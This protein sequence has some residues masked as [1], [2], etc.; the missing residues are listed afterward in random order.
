MS[1]SAVENRETLVVYRI[2]QN[3]PVVNTW[4]SFV[5]TSVASLINCFS[6]GKRWGEEGYIK[7]SRNK[8]DQCGIASMASYPLV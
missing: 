8:D 4:Q 5:D 7:M 3:T 6:W 1:T 2:L